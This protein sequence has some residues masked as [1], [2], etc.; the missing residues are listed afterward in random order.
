V[1]IIH[2]TTNTVTANMLGCEVYALNL[3]LTE[4][5]GG[6]DVMVIT[7]RPEALWGTC[8]RHDILVVAEENIDHPAATKATSALVGRFRNFGADVINCH[9]PLAA[10]VAVPAGNQLGVPCVFTCHIASKNYDADAGEIARV[11][12]NG[13]RFTTICV[14]RAM[15]KALK[16][17]GV[18]EGEVHYVPTGTKPSPRE[19]A[20]DERKSG[21]P[22]L[23]CV[24]ALESD[25]GTDL[26]ILAMVELRRRRGSDCPNLNIYGIGEMGEYYREMVAVLQL[27]DIVRLHGFQENILYRCP[28]SDIL[29]LSSRYEAAPLVVLEAMS[30]GM[31]IVSSEVGTVPEMLPDPRYGRTVPINSIVPLADAVESLL[32]EIAAGLFDPSLVIERHRSLYTLE[33]MAGRVEEVYMQAVA[34]NLA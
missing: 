20:Q 5:A 7:N 31:P 17:H 14:S 33:R 4:K 18:P 10:S 26:A 29:F 8:R 27:D 15:F 9:T 3:A 32:D 21:R 16:K 22:N 11:K 24:G 25:R 1:R 13:A 30:R 19:R 6:H 28:D 23:I 2:V 34:A 12:S